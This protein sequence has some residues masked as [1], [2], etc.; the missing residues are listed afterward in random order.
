MNSHPVFVCG[1]PK[2]GTYLLLSLFD[3][4]PELI[5]FPE[6]THFLRH[7]LGDTDRETP[8]Y[9]L[10]NTP[11]R[12]MNLG[13]VR[14]H[15]EGNRDYKHIDFTEYQNRVAEFWCKSDKTSRALLESVILSYGEITGKVEEKYW[16]EKTPQNEYYLNRAMKLWPKLRALYILR[17]P[18]DVYCSY[19][20]YLQRADSYYLPLEKII[21]SW[22][23]SVHF[24]ECFAAHNSRGLLIRYVD[25][26]QHPRRSMQ[27]VCNFLQ[28][29]WDDILLQPTRSGIRWGGNSMSNEEFAGISTSSLGKYHN[30]L[31]TEEIRF[32]ETWL[33]RV[34][35][36]YGWQIDHGRPTPHRM[37]TSLIQGNGTLRSKVVMIRN[38]LRVY[39]PGF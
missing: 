36:R 6:E 32:I 39:S 11:I 37:I 27:R 33:G 31:T 34:M 18:R 8:E 15:L 24:W 28:I 1:H 19:R 3:S 5:V 23:K 17:D 35:L 14:D 29:D 16:V 25:L 10:T 9:M 12:N 22:S 2:A 30:G 26:V 21:A 13:Q 7:V 20:T 38:L 4:H